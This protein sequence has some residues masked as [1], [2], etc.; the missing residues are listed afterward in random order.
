MASSSAYTREAVTTAMPSSAASRR[1]VGNCVPA[2]SFPDRMSA[3][4][5]STTDLYRAAGTASVYAGQFLGRHAPR[6]L[7]CGMHIAILTFEGYNEL[8][9]LI[10]LGLLNRV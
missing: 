6:V 8:D 5:A 3:A 4:K 10:A 2:H 1:W 7:Q 9:S